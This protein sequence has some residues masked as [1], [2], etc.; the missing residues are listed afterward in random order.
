METND[1]YLLLEAR[2]KEL[3]LSQSQLGILA[4]G[5]DNSSV[6][7][8]IRRGSSPAANKL[9]AICN[10]LDLEFYIGPK[11]S[12]LSREPV[13]PPGFMDA[14][15]AFDPTKPLPTEA[16]RTFLPIPYSSRAG[17]RRGVGPVAF[18]Q[19]W[20]SETGHAPDNLRFIRLQDDTMAPVA[21]ADTLVMIDEGSVKPVSDGVYAVSNNGKIGGGRVTQLTPDTVAFIALNPDRQPTVHKLGDHT[22]PFRILGR[23]VWQGHAI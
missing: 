18:S 23:V 16:E 7:Q 5:Q 17:G 9:E 20:L 22:Q 10:A 15:T 13:S 2:R 11:R 6:I 8:A 12:E 3:G 14:T 4:L 21:P 1:L 19:A